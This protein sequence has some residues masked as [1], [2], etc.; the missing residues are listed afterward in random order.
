MLFKAPPLLPGIRSAAT[1]PNGRFVAVQ[2]NL[3]GCQITLASVY[4]PVERQERA[5]FFQHRLMPVLPAGNT[6][7]LGGGTGTAWLGIRTWLGY[8]QAPASQDFHSGLLPLQQALGPLDSFRHLHPPRQVSL[9]T[10]PPQAHPQL[11]LIGRLS[12]TAWSQLSAQR[13]SRSFSQLTITD[14]SVAL[15]SCKTSTQAWRVVSATFHRLASCLQDSH[16]S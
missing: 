8:S 11:E 15:T 16:D 3:C 13:Q 9:P 10:Q 4:A 7:A 1:G 2:G 14:H 6:L 5:P 12:V